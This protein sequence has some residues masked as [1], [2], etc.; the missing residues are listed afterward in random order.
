MS[1]QVKNAG[2]AG[3][4]EAFL[5][6]HSDSQASEWYSYFENDASRYDSAEWMQGSWLSTAWFDPSNELQLRFA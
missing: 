4:A 5:P 3:Y 1:V 6:V 2:V